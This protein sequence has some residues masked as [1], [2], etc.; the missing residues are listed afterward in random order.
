MKK[1]IKKILEKKMSYDFSLENPKDKNLA[2]YASPLFALAKKEKKSPIELAENVAKDFENDENF[3]VSALKGYVNFK[4]KGEF[5]NSLVSQALKEGEDFAKVDI[6]H[7]K[8]LLE[9]VSA[10]P[11]GPLHI[12][13]VRGAVFG[14]V[15]QR[16]GNYLGDQVDTEYYVNDAGNQIYLLGLSIFLVGKESLL[17]ESVTFPE[18]YYKGEYI[19]DLAKEAYE[20]FGSDI[21]SS[22]ENISKLSFW[23]KDKML[24]LIQDNL[25]KANIH[26]ENYASEAEISKEL[27]KAL[28]KLKSVNALYEKDGSLWLKSSEKGDE[29]D[30]VVI[31]KDGT[32]TYLAGD[33]IY[34]YDKFLRSYDRYINIWG[35]DHH[36]YIAR[37]K[38]AMEFFGLESDKLEI[39][40]AQMVNLLKD[41]QAY[42]MSKRAG[43]FILMSEVNEEIGSDALRFI[44]I[45][46]KCDTALEFDVNELKK[47][48]SSNPIFYI[49]YAHARV[50]Q[51]FKKANKTF[52]EVQD[53]NLAE[54]KQDALNLAFEALMLGDVLADAYKSRSLQK[55]PDY[56]KNL[57]ANFHKFYNENKV[58]GSEKEAALLKLFSLIALNIKT[59]L[60]LLG[61][62]AKEKMEQA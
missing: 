28:E 10:N 18:Q 17:K 57:S 55:I 12:G 51:I 52:A 41:G 39:I 1:N 22:E 31:K 6:E 49:N 50:H 24:L 8:I 43:N 33:I 37:V 42:K 58:V 25:A 45:S 20:N 27:P 4:L 15:F 23:G 54:L 44:F 47:Q 56:L 2:H 46:K 53:A 40:L 60:N 29:K 5:I 61:I 14:D 38:A 7:E 48:D 26:I 13:H 32:S 30:R 21:F 19:E 34:H 11:T 3:E 16:V 59:A 62:Q 9:F 35:A 36:G